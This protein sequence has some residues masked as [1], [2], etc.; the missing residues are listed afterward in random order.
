MYM[1]FSV[2]KILNGQAVDEIK[3]RSEIPQISV[4]NR[5][6]P[7]LAVNWFSKI[8]SILNFLMKKLAI[9]ALAVTAVSMMKTASKPFTY[10]SRISIF[11]G[12]SS[13]VLEAK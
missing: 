5:S 8:L 11:L 13:M 3:Q 1:F 4:P 7:H 12:P 6:T 2:V 10:E 9:K